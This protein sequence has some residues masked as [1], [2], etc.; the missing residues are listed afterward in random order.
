M[1]EADELT[2][3]VAS[4]DARLE[5]AT[6]W[7]RLTF[8]LDGDWHHWLCAIAAPKSGVRLVFHKGVLLDDPAGLLTGSGRYVR[9][10]TA[11]AALAHPEQVRALVRE[12]ITHQTE[13][14]D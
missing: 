11:S 5:K 1:A 9:E 2:D 6:K 4:A 14:L 3:L 13:L 12:A 7:G 10:L 8:T